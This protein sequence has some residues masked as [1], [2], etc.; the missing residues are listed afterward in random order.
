MNAIETLRLTKRHGP[1]TAVDSLCLLSL[2][3]I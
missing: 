2:I 1:K 3:H